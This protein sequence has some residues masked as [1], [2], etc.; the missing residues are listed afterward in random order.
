MQ[1]DD[2]EIRS[3]GLWT[4]TALPFKHA[5]PR[6]VSVVKALSSDP[7]V[8]VRRTPPAS[9]RAPVHIYPNRQSYDT[10]GVPAGAAVE[11]AQFTATPGDEAMLAALSDRLLAD[12]D[13]SVRRA[14]AESIRKLVLDRHTYLGNACRVLE[15]HLPQVLYL[16]R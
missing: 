14:A 7:D 8:D 4:L 2:P 5:D 3:V 13:F 6:I 1:S 15:P 12:G 11:S 9:L 10:F 16:H